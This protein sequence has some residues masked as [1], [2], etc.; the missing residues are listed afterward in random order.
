VNLTQRLHGTAPGAGDVH[1]VQCSSSVQK[2][3][4]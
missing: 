2:W 1:A 3:I 4:A